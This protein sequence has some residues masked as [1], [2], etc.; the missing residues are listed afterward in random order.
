MTKNKLYKPV[1]V[2]K[3]V[4]DN[5]YYFVNKKYFPSVT[6]IIHEAM[7]T[8]F[9]LRYWIGEV[10]NEK[11][12]AR[13]KKAGERGTK[14]HDACEALL[15]GKTIHLDKDFPDKK[16]KKCIVSFIDWAYQTQ[17]TFNHKHIEF[18]V[19]SRK[20]Y[21]GTLDLFCYINKEPW[22][23]DFK[24]SAGIYNSHM[25][26]LCAY[27]HAFEEMTG[28]KA[29]MGI[30]HLNYR[31]KRGWSF[32]DKIQIKKK[33]ITIDDFLKVFEIYKMINGGIVPE[34]NLTEIYPSQVKL[35]DKKERK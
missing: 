11:A 10:G 31:T 9:A 18:T 15:R 5:H 20:K 27:Q 2:R 32:I 4:D 1:I 29:N 17:P 30:L 8:P 35:Y 19:A 6:K 24:T 3:D 13:L 22:I 12:E 21:A 16:D 14:I 7:P 33:P 26:Q 25:L 34:P 28:I 23:I